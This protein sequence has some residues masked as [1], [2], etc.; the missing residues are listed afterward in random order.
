MYCQVFPRNYNH[1]NKNIGLIQ[2]SFLVWCNDVLFNLSKD[3]LLFFNLMF[4][5]K[6]KE[7]VCV[8]ILRSWREA[9]WMVEVMALKASHSLPVVVLPSSP[10]HLLLMK[11][12]TTNLGVN[13]MA[14]WLEGN[15]GKYAWDENIIAEREMWTG[16]VHGI[17]FCGL[18]IIEVIWLIEW[19]NEWDCAIVTIPKSLSAHHS[20]S[21]HLT[22]CYIIST[23]KASQNI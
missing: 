9:L 3:C 12:I 13:R 8:Y 14:G 1:R 6:G 22:F 5:A 15:T 11:V 17:S 20:S 18:C 2:Y 4:H 7:E 10:K 23:V 16:S 21:S 19:Q